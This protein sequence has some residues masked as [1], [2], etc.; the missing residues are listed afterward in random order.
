MRNVFLDEE[1]LCG[2]SKEYDKSRGLM[3]TTR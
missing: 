3:H 2:T 1:A